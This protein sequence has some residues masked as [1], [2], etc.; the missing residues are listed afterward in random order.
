MPASRRQCVAPSGSRSI[1]TP[2][3]SSTSAAP[4]LEDMLRLPCLATGTPQPATTKDTA[5]E[6]LSVPWPSPPVPHRSIA[7][8]GA[9]IAFMLARMTRAAPTISA[10]VGPRRDCADR[11]AARSSSLTVAGHDG[12]ERARRCALVER[13]SARR[14]ASSNERIPQRSCRN[15]REF[16]RERQEILQQRVAVLRRDAFGMELDAMDGMGFVHHA[17]DDAVVAGGGD[18]ERSPACFPARW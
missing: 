16:F 5:V 1:F 17:L 13:F 18:F 6:M 9:S 15:A 3:A 4:L 8:G 2:S 12:R 11:N 7:P 14:R 10:T